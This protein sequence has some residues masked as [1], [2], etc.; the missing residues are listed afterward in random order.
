MKN[1]LRS[2]LLALYLFVSMQGIAWAGNFTLLASTGILQLSNNQ[3]WEKTYDTPDGKFKIR[4]RKLWTSSKQKRF[5]LIIWR[6]KERIADGYCPKNESGY[7]FSIYR[8]N[9]SGRLF[10]A[11]A[12]RPRVVLMGYEPFNGRLEVYADSKSYYSPIPNPQLELDED[13]DLLLSFVGSGWENPTRYKLFW[14]EKARWFGYKN[15]TAHQPAEDED[16]YEYAPSYTETYDI[17]SYD[18]DGL[19][20]EQALYYVEVV[21]VGS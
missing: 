13:N 11:L 5:H 19:T 1:A 16:D 3:K 8:D 4:F 21:E 20:N 14:D 9:S 2:V 15:V 12:S 6:D 7:S 10:I 17:S 18:P